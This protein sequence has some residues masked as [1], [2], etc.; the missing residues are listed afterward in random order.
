MKNNLSLV[1]LACCQLLIANSILSQHYNPAK[2]NKKAQQYFSSGMAKADEGS[3]AEAISLLE[4]AIYTDTGYV[5]AYMALGSV[6]NQQKKYQL[7]TEYYEQAI[8]RDSVYTK[9]YRLSYSLALAGKGDFKKAL[10]VVDQ[11]LTDP[12]L[13]PGGRKRAEDRKHNYEFGVEFEKKNAGKK[14]LF[15][16]K[17]LGDGINSKYSEYFPSLTIDGSEFMITR[18]LSAINE[19]FFT[20]KKQ[21]NQWTTTIPLPGDV[22]TD[23][24]EGALMISQDGQVLTFAAFG[25]PGGRGNF[26]IYFSYRNKDK[27]GEPQ[28]AGVINSDQWDSQPC[29][30]PDK[31][32]LYFSSRRIG[33]F[34]GA[35]IYVSNLLPNGNWGLPINL[36]PTVNT[37]TDEQC[38]FIHA[39]NQTLFFTSSGL[40]GYG[41]DD[42]YY[43]KLL[44]DGKWSTPVNLG[45]PINTIDREGTLYIAA[46]GKTAYYAGER[47]DSRGGL[48][49][50]SFELREDMRPVK[51]LWVKGKV[52]DKKTKQGLSSS[53]ELIDLSSNV[54]ISNVQT[55]Q[56]GNYL[57]TLPTGKDYAFSVNKKGYLFYSDNF[58]LSQRSPDSIYEKNITLSPIEKDA[59]IVLKNIF[60][61]TN[62]F[63]L[64]SESQSEL[65][66]LVQLLNEN[67]T[68]KI[69]ISGHTDSIGKAPDNLKLSQSRAKAVVD[70]LISKKITAT[71]LTSKGF[72][73]TKPVAPNK[74]EDG[75]AMNRRTEMKVISQ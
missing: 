3:F 51:T 39:D 23:M 45:Y 29:L 47:S 27:W 49:I 12:K 56:Q 31:K 67:P 57:T 70:Y 34:G 36:G 53:V 75:R 54:V 48:D 37:A 50:Y 15:D 16:P 64:K 41:D 26:D 73:S 59:S 44:P 19:D 38:P 33:G 22:N 66:K 9:P 32:H 18:K 4:I 43:T 7:A 42:L 72:G 55:D 28:N 8:A 25:R 5:D 60:F 10:S 17:N 61:E 24:N 46:D 63:N 14:Y 65:D 52:T 21:N 58:L 71:R 11:Y 20:S 74:T 13:S 6:Y 40:P 35:D 68:L 1:F 2:I 30:S 62:K 69:E